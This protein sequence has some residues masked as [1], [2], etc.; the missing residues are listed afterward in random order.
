MKFSKQRELILNHILESDAHLSADIIYTELKQNNPEL[1][2]GTVYRNL[3]QLSKMKIIKKTSFPNKVERFDKK[4]EPHTHLVCEDCGKIVDVD[5][6][7]LEDFMKN[8]SKNKNLL[9]KT[10]DIIFNGICNECVEKK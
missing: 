9:I 8:I 2:L 10:C 6:D 1:S 3:S 5:I 7:N 4:L